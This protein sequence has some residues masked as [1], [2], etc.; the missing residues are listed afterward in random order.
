MEIRDLKEK[1]RPYSREICRSL[2]P[3][4]KVVGG[5]WRIGNVK[6][7]PGES[8]SV[9]LEDGTWTDFES[10]AHGDLLDLISVNMGI[11]LKESMDYARKKFGIKDTVAKAISP[12]VKSKKWA[13][14]KPPARSNTGELHKFLERRGF[15]SKDLGDICYKYKIYETDKVGAGID[16]VFQLFNAQGKLSYLKSKPVNYDG[17]PSAANNKDMK[18]C[19][20]GWHTL[21]PNTRQVWLVEGEMD[22]IVASELG[23]PALSVPNGAN[24]SDKQNNADWIQYE[25]EDLERFEEIV[26]ATDQ[27]VA[28]EKCA[29]NLSARLGER[30][31]RVRFPAKDIND[32]FLEHG[33]E[34]AAQILED[35]YKD[36][37]W[38]DPSQLQNVANFADEIDKFFEAAESN[39]TGFS[40]GFDKLDN[41]D[42]RFR[43]GELWGLTGINGSGKSMWLNQ[44]ALNAIKQNK[45]VL[46]ASMEMTP[47]YTMGRMM[48]QVT[49]Q[50]LP[51]KELRGR[52]LD[53]LSPNLWL[54]VDSLTP[55]PDDLLK[56][57]KYA[58]Q[59]Y[60]IDIFIV[61]SMTNLVRH[62][63]YE[64]QQKLMEKLV[65]FKMSYNVTMFLVTHARK[66]E[67]ESKAPGKFDVKGTGAITDLA[68]GFMSVWKNKAKQDHIRNCQLLGEAPDE[69]VIRKPDIILEVLKNRHGMFEGKNGFYFDNASCQYV[70]RQGLSPTP[71]VKPKR[72]KPF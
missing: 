65:D 29:E 55:K 10:G 24:V 40:S 11:T 62:D 12:V 48:R 58:F 57:F 8:M 28:G 4:G 15:N 31:L 60:G 3:D 53:W 47:R 30:C 36:A 44:L 41:E 25:W 13:T 64:G 21:S 72:E 2:L 37:K 1:L 18:P 38:Q 9:R 19:L 34:T 56:V 46:I 22:Y 59:R 52:S 54:Y 66:G 26:L 16:V 23:L 17:H 6:G 68:D 7:E 35:A 63:D 69:D 27:D 61:D 45:K 32:L 14:P 42:I 50:T 49:A 43:S 67:S 70:E 20:Y 71:Y 39:L 5:N 33:A 51:D